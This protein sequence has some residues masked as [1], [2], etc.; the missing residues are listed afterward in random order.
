[1]T[2]S[3]AIEQF[4]RLS[5]VMPVV[6]LTD[7]AVAAGLARAL[8]RG[9]IRVM[10]VTLR[11]PVALRA[12]EVIAR[13]VPEITVGAG[14]VLSIADL[15]A[16]AAAGAAFAISPGATETL[17]S[18]GA[19]GPIPYLPAVASAS[20]LMA[21]WAAG[22][23]CFKF[24]PAGAAGGIAMLNALGGPFP[25]ARFCPTGGI[26]QA[27]VKSYLDLPNVLCAGGSWL[28]PA[29]AL[30]KKDWPAIESLASRAAASRTAAG[31]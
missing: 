23:R 26:T 12:I 13:E 22:Y 9:G 1:M 24:F 19:T 7:A 14:T 6:T 8:V 10:E 4:L 16:C 15:R 27:S 31:T 2:H 18:A 5:P 20:E 30:S 25:E 17:L 11:T 21:G 29:E 3:G 28:T